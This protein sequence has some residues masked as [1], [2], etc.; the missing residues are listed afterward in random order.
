MYN[1]V[2]YCTILNH[3]APKQKHKGIDLYKINSKKLIESK[4]K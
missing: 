2:P 3:I 1:T 4:A